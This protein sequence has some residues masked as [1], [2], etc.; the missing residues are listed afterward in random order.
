MSDAC[1]AIL[2]AAVA[3]ALIQQF[4]D[5]S[6]SSQRRI[7][8]GC[9]S[10][11][12]VAAFLA[13]YPDWQK[14]VGI[15]LFFVGAMA[16]AAY[17]YTPYLKIRGK[18]YALNAVDSQPDLDDKPAE[19]AL[20]TNDHGES[21]P[22]PDSYSGLLTARKMWWVLTVLM[23]IAAINVWIFIESGGKDWVAGAAMVL[24]IFFA[25]ILGLGDASWGYGIARGQKVQFAIA[26]IIT[27]G[28]FAV[29]YLIAYWIGKRKPV[30]RKQSMEYRAHPRHQREAD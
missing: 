17:G 14:G 1:F 8:W 7:Y 29:I 2:V 24:I 18:V 19:T 20:D 16:A 10:I 15:G 12:A 30:H 22:A 5:H 21:D 23:L 25:V 28:T 11:G 6:R 27:A 3:V 13:P 26:T 9:T 4:F